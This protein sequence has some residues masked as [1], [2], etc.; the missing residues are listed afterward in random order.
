ML[1]TNFLKIYDPDNNYP[2]YLIKLDLY[3][4]K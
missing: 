4:I 3:Q 1:G 2:R